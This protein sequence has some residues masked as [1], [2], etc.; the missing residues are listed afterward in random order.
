M[1]GGGWLAPRENLGV[2]IRC[3]A[4]PEDRGDD[5]GFRVALR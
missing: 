2:A 4:E 5:Q 3:R 1:R